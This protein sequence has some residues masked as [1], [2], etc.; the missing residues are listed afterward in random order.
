MGGRRQF[1]NIRRRKNGKWQ[2]TYE[3]RGRRHSLGTFRSKGEASAALSA[4]ETS[5]SLGNW[6]DPKAG[7][8]AFG[9]YASNW[10]EM[11]TGIRPRTRDQYESLFKNHLNPPLGDLPMGQITT[12]DVRTWHAN[13][14]KRFPGT[15]PAAY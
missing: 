13:I 12:Y 7:K 1:G 8:V 14:Y 2:A 5:L 3:V 9:T 10:L 6:I 11:R 4:I 15:A